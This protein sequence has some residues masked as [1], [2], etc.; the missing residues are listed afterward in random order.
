VSPAWNALWAEARTADILEVAERLGAR[1]K[2]AS[3]EFHGACPAGCA[4]TDGFIV[5][6]SR[7]L[8]LC[9]PSGESGD[10][11]DMVV[12]VHACTK[13]E[14]LEFV[15]QKPLPGKQPETTEERSRREAQTRRREA[16][17]KARAEREARDEASRR[18]RDEEAVEAILK[19]ATAIWGTHAEAYLRARGINP[20]RP[21]AKDL[22]FCPDLDYWSEIEGK[23]ILV[24]TLPALVSVIRDINGA[25]I[26]VQR[27]YLEPNEPRKYAAQGKSNKK[28]RGDAKGGLIRLGD[29]MRPTLAIS[30]GV[31]N[32]FAWRAV[33]MPDTMDPDSVALACAVSLG[34]LAGGWTGSRPHPSRINEKTGNPTPIP[35]AI[36]NPDQPGAVL[37]AGVR[38]LI[39]IGDSDSEPVATHRALLTAV[40]RHKA[41]GITVR[42]HLPP[43]SLDWNDTLIALAGAALPAIGEAA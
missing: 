15:V 26:G 10:A 42:V 20:P 40:R 33:G 13:A 11:V 36:P 34:N 21:M 24:A 27:T 29:I 8:F 7:G 25:V 12:H 32:A 1:L 5:T 39:L 14:A 19:R 6:P 43:S 17:L 22:R 41:N 9:R 4:S 31:E 23:N 38:D 18:L 35:N 2:R 30:E 28:I 16:A 37:P 3:N